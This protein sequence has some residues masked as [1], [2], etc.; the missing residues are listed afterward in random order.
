MELESEIDRAV[1][2]AFVDLNYDM[3]PVLARLSA[4]RR[5]A[6][7]GELADFARASYVAQ[8]QRANPDLSPSEIRL[9]VIERMLLHG[10]VKREVIQQV[11]RL[12][13]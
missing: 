10:G 7:V 2:E 4:E 13:G 9:R 8:E 6:M 3:I 12:G 5:F 11:C 1:R